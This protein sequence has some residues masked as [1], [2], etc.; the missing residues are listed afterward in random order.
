MS[1]IRQGQLFSWEEF[2]ENEDDNTHLVLVLDTLSD[3][4]LLKWLRDWRKG[5]RNEYPLAVLWRGV[6]AKFVYQIKSYAELIRELQRNGSLRRL[7]G[8]RRQIEAGR[9]QRFNNLP[10]RISQIARIRSAFGHQVVG[11]SHYSQLP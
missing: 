10:L 6:I 7:V 2:V 5:R 8:R 1:Y 9:Q 3:G 11:H 4:K